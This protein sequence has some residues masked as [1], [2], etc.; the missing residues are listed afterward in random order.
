MRFRFWGVRGSVPCPLTAQGLKAKVSA[1]L[2]RVRP[3]DLRGP[4]ARE[5]FLA[6]LPPELFGLIGGNT[7][8]FEFA[9]EDNQV[10]IV[11]GGTGIRELGLHHEG[12][13]SG[14]KHYHIFL[15]HFHW[16]H[17]QGLPFFSGFFHGWNQVTFYSPIPGFEGVVRGQMKEPYFPVPLSAYPATVRFVEL[18]SPSV[19]IGTTKV[20]WKQVNHPGSCISYRFEQGP[21]SLV[22]STDTELR[23]EDFE[24]DEANLLFY[25]GA[26]VLIL[27]AQYTLEE[28]VDRPDWG[29]SASSLAVDFAIDFGVRTLYLFHHEP[30]HDDAKIEEIGRLAQW[31]ADH[32]RPGALVVRL[33]REG[34]EEFIP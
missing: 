4:D 20:R 23:I 9:S 8:C 22:F 15:T 12:I 24:K 11:D 32:R 6:T 31:Y 34:R 16:D 26:E 14:G 27:D 29:H 21:H 30:N 5:R 7:S 13:N 19:T 33:A 1:I 10:L 18:T 3:Q 17:L 28:A 2:Q 25:Q